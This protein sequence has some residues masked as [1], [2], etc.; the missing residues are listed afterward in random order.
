MRYSVR[1]QSAECCEF[2]SDPECHYAHFDTWWV[3]RE[4]DLFSSG[5]FLSETLYV[6]AARR[7]NALE[8][9]DADEAVRHMTPV[10]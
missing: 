10:N 6:E 1:H 2:C 4:T 3:A 9:A 8:R 5:P 7:L